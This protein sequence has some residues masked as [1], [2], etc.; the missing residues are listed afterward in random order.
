MV[1]NDAAPTQPRQ[2]EYLMRR[3]PCLLAALVFGFAATPLLA[4]EPAPAATSASA[5]MIVHKD[6]F[7]G[8]C[9][10]W[11]EHVRAAGIEVEARNESDMASIKASL[12]VP[13][14]MASCHTA[15]I[16]GYFI[17]GHVPV[18]DIQR[19]LAE[20]PD[21]AGLAVP[22]MPAGSPGMEMPDGRSDPYT[23]ELVQR[24]GSR[25]TFSRH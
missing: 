19:L 11:I 1:D 15:T 9:N 5:T 24:D 20:A 12:G 16:G 25:S 14:A 6:P 13:A 22:G 23:V 21:A 18:E 4:A 7:C 10:Q 17:E 2:M 3:I 8:C